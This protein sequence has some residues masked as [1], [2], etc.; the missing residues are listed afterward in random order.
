MFLYGDSNESFALAIIVPN[1]KTIEDYARRLNIVGSYEQLCVN[2]MI[3][4]E[5]LSMLNEFG[6]K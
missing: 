3:R 5:L 1:Q 2:P 4:K 6:K